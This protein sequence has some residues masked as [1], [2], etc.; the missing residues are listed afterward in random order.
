MSNETTNHFQWCKYLINTPIK[1]NGFSDNNLNSC[2][3]LDSFMIVL[4]SIYYLVAENIVT[5]IVANE[6]K[7]ETD[8]MRKLSAAPYFEELALDLLGSI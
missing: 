5:A 2:S 8:E 7:T 1:S 3:L 4:F 6:I